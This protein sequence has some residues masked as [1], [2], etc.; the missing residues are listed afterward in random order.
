MDFLDIAHDGRYFAD[1]GAVLEHQGGNHSTRVDRPIGLGMLLT[2][3]KI[4]WNLRNRQ[5]LLG[6]ENAHAP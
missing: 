4:D 2:F 5:A 1:G 3:A 6:E